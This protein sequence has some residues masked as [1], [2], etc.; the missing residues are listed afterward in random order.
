MMVG[1][2][3]QTAKPLPA[4]RLELAGVDQL[5]ID[6]VDPWTLRLCGV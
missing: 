1:I 2:A 5:S 3:R 4:E 6:E